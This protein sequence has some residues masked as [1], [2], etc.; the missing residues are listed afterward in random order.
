M[1]VVGH[2]EPQSRHGMANAVAHELGRQQKHL[3]LVG[4]EVPF[5]E[6]TPGDLAHS[7]GARCSRWKSAFNPEFRNVNYG[8]LTTGFLTR[9]TFIFLR[10]APPLRRRRKPRRS[11]P[12]RGCVQTSSSGGKNVDAARH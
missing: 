8:T 3:L 1:A 5:L 7:T 2:L 9:L 12:R 4:R 11:I 6:G 10:D